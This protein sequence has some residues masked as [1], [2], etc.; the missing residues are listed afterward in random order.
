[1]GVLDWKSYGQ[2]FARPALGPLL[3]QFFF[4]AFSF[5]MFVNG[6]ALFAE[7]R[8]KWHGKPFDA[9]QVGFILAWVGFLGII[10][11]GGLVGRLVKRFGELAL[12]RSGFAVTAVTAFWL[13][14]ITTVPELI[15]NTGVS[16]F[17]SGVVRPALTALI[18][19]KADK[20]EQ[21][22]VLGLTQSLTS[23]T[24]I[25]APVLAG[26]LIDRGWLGAWACGVGL[27]AAFGTFA[28]YR[29]R[30]SSTDYQSSFKAT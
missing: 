26:A 15:A 20:H 12:V 22:V 5:S 13:A 23:V 17:G 24:Q 1:V 30:A 10:I 7:R 19:H 14:R 28:A 25:V 6:F 21:G 27:V 9:V 4:F 3:L 11:Q 29:Y 16:S 2:Y 8:F 18:T